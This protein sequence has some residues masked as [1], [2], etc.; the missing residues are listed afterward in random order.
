MRTA[1]AP[2]LDR[3]LKPASA[4]R[5][6]GPWLMFGGVG[7]L[8]LYNRDDL[9]G[10]TRRAP[11]PMTG[12][13]AVRRPDTRGLPDGGAGEGSAHR[14]RGA[15]RHRQATGDNPAPS[16]AMARRAVYRNGADEMQV[17]AARPRG[18]GK[19][20][21]DQVDRRDEALECRGRRIVPSRRCL[22]F[23]ERGSAARSDPGKPV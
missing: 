11:P 20:G 16:P 14:C 4:A 17:R 6:L 15:R 21:V 13:V 1:C 23:R 12:L 18:G 9:R 22:S 2:H 3:A 5:P 7:W 8:I 19:R 10:V